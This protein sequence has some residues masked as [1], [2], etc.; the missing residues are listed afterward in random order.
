MK[1]YAGLDIGNGYVKGK[2]QNEETKATYN[3]DIA[4]CAAYVTSDS[5]LKAR[6]EE[7]QGIIDNI[8]DQMD[9]TFDTNLV[10][11][12]TNR[13]F[14]ERAIHSD[15][16]LE[17]FDVLS[18]AS[19]CH[20]DIYGVL[21]LASVAGTALKDY[22]A[23]NN[24]LPDEDEL[25]KVNARIAIALP[26]REYKSYRDICAAEYKEGTHIVT[27]HNFDKRIRIQI[28]FDNVQVAA[29]GASAQFALMLHPEL[30]EGM[31]NECKTNDPEFD[32]T[33]TAQDVI[34]AQN[35]IGIDIGEG[36]A[37]MP[38]FTDGKFNS[39]ASQTLNKGYGNVLTTALD[40]L[41]EEGYPFNDRKALASYLQS[42]PSR[43][44]Q[45]RYN[46]I[47]QIVDEEK[48]AYV[49]ELKLK[50]S[51][52]LS[53]SGAFTEVIYVYGGGANPLKEQLYSVL[54]ESL[55][56]SNLDIPV[57]YLDSSYSRNLNREGLFYIVNSVAQSEKKK[58][59]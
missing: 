55:K 37:N 34:N 38:V 23:T 51:R 22:F 19:K 59:A 10:K 6:P 9:L 57:L 56:E 45:N 2:C 48:V 31:L 8:Y 46:K 50:F 4:S 53:S 54:H 29:E 12:T 17:Q 27:F 58:S 14:G 24:K 49:K 47:S 40:R 33:I 16:T 52:V 36:T 44:S 15:R 5:A 13:L 28:K 32:Q 39:D 30:I 41:T 18:N 25:I 20:Q 11:D 7:I 43:L 42:T 3:I 35:I 26:I 1:L 21:I